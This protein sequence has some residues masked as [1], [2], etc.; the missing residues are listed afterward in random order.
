MLP[1]RSH[2]AAGRPSPCGRPSPACPRPRRACVVRDVERVAA[3]DR[4]GERLAVL[5]VVDGRRRR[6]RRARR[7]GCRSPP[8]RTSRPTRG[9]A[10]P[11]CSMSSSAPSAAGRRPGRGLRAERG[12]VLEGRRRRARRARRR[13]GP[14]RRPRPRARPRTSG[15]GRAAG[16][17]GAR[18]ASSRSRSASGARTSAA[19]PRISVTARRWSSSAAASCGVARGHRLDLRLARGRQR[20]V[21]SGGEIRHQAVV[22]GLGQAHREEI[23]HGHRTPRATY[24]RPA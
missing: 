6:G 16:P 24:A 21:G 3:D 12:G 13:A 2:V 7:C 15:G 22:V 11:S 10:T 19:A 5:L 14:P 4:V 20:A 18:S 9:T 1:S 23:L 8:S 17:A